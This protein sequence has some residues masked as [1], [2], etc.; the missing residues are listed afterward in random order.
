MSLNVQHSRTGQRLPPVV[1]VIEARK[2]DH[3][4][5][6]S[7]GISPDGRY[8]ALA[9]GIFSEREDNG[10]FR[11]VPLTVIWKINKSLEFSRRM[12]GQPWAEVKYSQF[13]DEQALGPGFQCINFVDA[14]CLTPS[15]QIATTNWDLL[16]F[17]IVPE[18]QCNQYGI[19]ADICFFDSNGNIY[20]CAQTNTGSW[21]ALM[22]L[23]SG[24]NAPNL[25][26]WDE[27]S[28]YVFDVSTF[29][30]YLV[31]V[32]SKTSER[33]FHLFDT[34]T[35]K[36]EDLVFPFSTWFRDLQI[37]RF[38][39]DDRK[40]VAFIQCQMAGIWIMNVVIWNDLSESRH[41]SRHGQL[42]MNDGI[43]SPFRVF[44]HQHGKSAFI[45]TSDRY[46][47][48]VRLGDEV[49]FPN[50]KVID[51]EY[52]CHS[53]KVSRDGRRLAMPRYGPKKA[54]VQISQLN[55][56]VPPCQIQLQCLECDPQFLTV[57]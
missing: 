26:S 1:E 31:L 52:I 43:Q 40:L 53:S 11:Q 45:V 2:H 32:G 38:C 33:S 47:Q 7:C 46:I 44:V 8:I 24:L 19:E 30:R 18:E 27:S 5:V 54:Y 28:K 42:P 14:Y 20:L 41:Y 29:G 34:I 50:A 16:P 55:S 6:Q 39:E 37:F 21:Q 22:F 36:V 56:T 3:T 57:A 9:Y 15:G 17:L 49:N 23:P 48:E 25:Y 13:T 35:K 12:N 10:S 4:W 51:D